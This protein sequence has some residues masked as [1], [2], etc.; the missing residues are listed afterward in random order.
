MPVPTITDLEASV[1]FAE[2]TVNASPQV[3][4]PSVAFTAPDNSFDGGWLRV[5][6]LLAEDTVSIRNQG[7][8]AGEIGLSGDGTVT[9]G[10]VAIGTATGG[11]GQT[12]TVVFNATATVAAIDALIQNLTYA[13]TSDT[14]TSARTLSIAVT[15]AAV[16]TTAN[17]H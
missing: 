5:T 13:N 12:F 17:S 9:Y 4:D 7:T 16:P 2:N 1:A 10:G 11:A 8:A 14:P 6:G 15:N 3:I